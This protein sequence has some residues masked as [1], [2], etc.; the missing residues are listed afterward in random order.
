M[1]IHRAP[2]LL[3][4]ASALPL[5]LRLAFSLAGGRRAGLRHPQ[6][7]GFLED[8]D[9]FAK[10]PERSA[11]RSSTPTPPGTCVITNRTSWPASPPES[12][13]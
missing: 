12:S 6:F 7:A 3:L 13:T 9:A 4:C 2:R 8:V 1:R 10:L 11:S 5:L